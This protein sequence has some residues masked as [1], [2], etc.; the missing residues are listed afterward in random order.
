MIR[1][2][3]T[4]GRCAVCGERIIEKII[5][6]H[7]SNVGPPIFGPASRRQFKEVREYYCSFCG[8]KYE[9]LPRKPN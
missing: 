1:T 6:E 5:T 8:V 4:E 7:D 3:A 2:K 9:F